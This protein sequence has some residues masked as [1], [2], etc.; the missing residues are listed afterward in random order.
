MMNV[1]SYVH[2]EVRKLYPDAELPYFECEAPDEK[3]MVMT[4]RSTRPLADLA[5]G[6]IAG[7]A[8]HFGETIDIAREDLPGERGTHVRFTLTKQPLN[9]R[10]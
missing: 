4:Y 10:D 1:E 9:E 8:A 5:E 2:V 3:H 6:L 7:C